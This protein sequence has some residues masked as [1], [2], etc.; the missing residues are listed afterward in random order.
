MLRNRKEYFEKPVIISTLENSYFEEWFDKKESI[1]NPFQM[2]LIGGNVTL[3]N[4]HLFHTISSYGGHIG[5]GEM[6][7]QH[8]GLIPVE[9]LRN[10]CYLGMH[11]YQMIYTIFL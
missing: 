11:I 2:L 1:E 6:S 3:K 5:K 9:G 10:T 4:D 7:G 8:F